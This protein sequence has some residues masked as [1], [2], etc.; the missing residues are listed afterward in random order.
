[1]QKRPTM[2]DVARE[3]NV[4]KAT[5][6]LA[7][8]G[9]P[10]ISTETKQKVFLVCQKLGYSP[11]VIAQ[12]LARSSISPNGS[13][14]LGT[15]GILVDARLE[16]QIKMTPDSYPWEQHLARICSAMGYKQDRFVVGPSEK[17]QKTISRVLQ[18][19]GIT[20]LFILGSN[21]PVH[22]WALD[23][24]HF[25]AVAYSSSL[26]EH[27][28]HNVMSNS[29][30]DVYEATIRLLNLGYTRP[31][32]LRTY[33]GL[34]HWD[35]GFY[36]AMKTGHLMNSLVP[37]LNLP[38][39]LSRKTDKGKLLAWIKQYQPDVIIANSDDRLLHLLSG[40]GIRV[41]EDIGFLCLDVWESR[42]HLS[43][44]RQ[45]KEDAFQV[46]MDLLHGMLVR[47]ELGPPDWP[48]CVQVPS[49]WNEGST[50]R[51]I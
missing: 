40:A 19:R 1:M 26:H 25:S 9:N 11:N 23:W 22:T 48:T 50:L 5:V 4:T 6:S 42:K 47:H 34:D 35:A 46:A 44:L 21:E 36:S 41:P 8:N 10:R 13:R 27:F 32:Y 12:A 2:A 28:I 3:A 17:E 24:K 15:L 16:Q 45:M 39:F 7:L 37:N 20:G 18:A 31:G 29:Y 30:Q 33:S 49:L 51:R 14:F 38:E 43:G